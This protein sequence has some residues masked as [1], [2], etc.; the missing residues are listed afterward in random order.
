MPQLYK[1]EMIDMRTPYKFAAIYNV[2]SRRS[3]VLARVITLGL[4]LAVIVFA[5]VAQRRY[6]ATAQESA[7]ARGGETGSQDIRL[8]E[9]A[10]DANG[11]T[12][13][14]HHQP[15]NSLLLSS[16][17]GLELLGTA[18]ARAQLARLGVH[19]GA[20][21][22]ARET[23]NGFIAGDI[24]AGADEPGVILR[25]LS[26]AMPGGASAKSSD[27]GSQQ[28]W[29]VLDGEAGVVS[30]LYLSRQGA[31]P[32]LF[33]SPSLTLSDD[34]LA[35]TTEGGVWRIDSTGAARRVTAMVTWRSNDG[36]ESPASFSAV[37]LA[38]NDSVKYGAL[39]GKILAI[40]GGQG[41]IYAIDVDGRVESFDLGLRDLNNLLLIPAKE[42]FFGVTTHRQSGDPQ[43]SDRAGDQANIQKNLSSLQKNLSGK[44]QKAPGTI[45]GAAAAEF[46][47]IAGDFLIT[48][49]G[50]DAC[51][52]RPSIWS[53]R[54]NGAE[55]E[56]TKLAELS[57]APRG[58][59][60]GQV[61]FSP[62]GGE[63]FN[64]TSESVQLPALQ[65][66]K[67]VADLNGGF[68]QPGDTLEYTLT[69]SNPSSVSVGK[70]FIAEFI[71]ANT[72]YVAGSVRITSGANSGAKTDAMDDDQLDTFKSGDR[73]VQLNIAIGAGGGGRL[74]NGI[75]R[76]GSLAPGESST[77][78]FRVTVKAGLA[79]GSPI[80]NG[81]QW[82]AEDIYPGG[83]SNIVANTTGSPLKLEKSV[84]DLNGG[85]VSP[86]DILEYKLILTNQSF[87]QVSRSFIAEFIPKGVTYVP[88]SVQITAGANTGAKTDAIDND[89]VDFFSAAGVNGQLNIA[90]GAGAGGHAAGGGL[91]GGALAAGE[92]TTIVF[93][94]QVNTGAGIEPVIVNAANAGAND[95]YPIANSNVVT[96]AVVVATPLIGPFGQPAATGPTGNNDDFTVGKVSLTVSNGLTV[97]TGS[98]RFINT[99]K[100]VGSTPGKF[101][102]SA[103]TI[104]QGFSVKVSV[105]SGASF[106]SLNQG[107]TATTPTTL[108]VNEE[109]NIDVRVDLPVGLAI[110]TNYD[111]VIQAAWDLDPTQA[112]RT[113][114]R[115]R[116]DS[117][118][119]NLTLTKSVRDL[120][121]KDIAGGQVL[122]GQTIEYSLTLSNPSNVA[123]GNSSIAEFLPPNVTYVA[124]STQITTGPNAGPKTD[125]R[126]DD[127]VDFFPSGFVN[128]Q[129]NIFTGTG[130]TALKGGA[131]AA[132]ESTTVTFRVKINDNV[133]TGTAIPNGANWG[134]EDFAIG[135]KSNIV[136]VTVTC[137]TITVSPLALPVG[138]VGTAYNQTITQ[139][140]GVAPITFT[141]S[142]GALPTGLTLDPAT[143]VLSGKPTAAGPFSF[144][145]KATD[146]NGCAGVQPYAVTITQ[147]PAADC[148]LTICFRSAAYF[149]LNFGT[150][151]I[152]NGT[153]S[154]AGV[155]L[156]NPIPTT[157][158]RVK[159]ALNEQFGTF[160]REYVAAQLNLLAASGLGAANVATALA[161][162]LSCYGL[163]FDTVT[164]S[165]GLVLS[166]Q[167]PL[168]DVFISA[169]AVAKGTSA[170]RDI[171]IFTR[172]FIALNG[173]SS[174]NICN[175]PSGPVDLIAACTF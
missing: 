119:P 63:L 155:N 72:D 26:T 62:F 116:P 173:N 65:L 105:D 129:I 46:A 165:T 101:V 41:K 37:T 5:L 56:K 147:A 52:C 36:V 88:N 27:A 12:G 142:A 99:V 136:T 175:R 125:A 4:T 80:I 104:P 164:L 6:A 43:L 21:A 141:I 168:S 68:I 139:T 166:T 140:G 34:L 91:I 174:A 108:N 58:V 3:S 146:A 118:P 77:V 126:G 32:N 71:P 55:F 121:G 70:S 54:W 95:I 57:G 13:I 35:V 38:P 76:G 10:S 167:S 25:L 169:S 159:Q 49:A 96:S 128:G 9:I 24:F 78:V 171:C 120:S 93:R 47:S 53:I 153:V 89:Q 143:G 132:G 152:P 82:G 51:Q 133:A 113:I 30:G 14:A 67:S 144:T 20:L 15:S 158:Q 28:R 2:I 7:Q 102:I 122:R 98:L 154:I 17:A 124:G 157:D 112:N 87:S 8:I 163:Q 66:V 156:G 29:A 138:V 48:Q 107:M 100:N 109:R 111:V 18:G 73:V 64:E 149:S 59:E 50:S 162:Q 117:N 172:L 81:A 74:G 86:R 1:Q 16:E 97:E 60:W 75:L 150:T 131:L 33:D 123:V 134:A 148:R 85:Q 137:P 84:T 22:T 170:N 135:G 40:A 23:R 79:E 83:N 19:E 160:N 11:S 130:A 151:A 145:V 127:Q 61:T 44:Q 39:A 115:A 42:N 114:D 106:V 92:S 94:A 161:S 69:L 103:P 90:T 45:W 31:T 110:N